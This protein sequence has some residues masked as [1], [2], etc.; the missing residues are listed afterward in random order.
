MQRHHLPSSIS[1]LSLEVDWW[2]REWH[3]GEPTGPQV[4]HVRGLGTNLCELSGTEIVQEHFK[5]VFRLGRSRNSPKPDKR[6]LET[7]VVEFATPHGRASNQFG[8][9]PFVEQDV[10]RLQ[11]VGAKVR[12]V[13]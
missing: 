12:V 2:R 8:T 5:C 3:L 4:G 13:E 10:S 1:E 7:A 9:L 11:P 6:V